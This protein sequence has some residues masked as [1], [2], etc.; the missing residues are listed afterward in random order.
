MD[1][2]NLP[3]TMSIL[4]WYYMTQAL[5]QGYEGE[6]SKWKKWNG[7]MVKSLLREQ[8]MDGYWPCP[9]DKYPVHVEKP[10][11][12]NPKKMIKEEKVMPE[13]SYGGFS[14]INGRLWAT[15]YFCMSL[16]VYYRY[17]PTFKVKDQ[18][19]KSGPASDDMEE[20]EVDD[21]DLSL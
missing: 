14:E 5:F 12:E 19:Q 13:S 2:K 20:E 9:A 15:V 18:P 11:P 10:D 4:G 3:G 8:H 16:E 17:L 1:W 6:G 7:S 21:D